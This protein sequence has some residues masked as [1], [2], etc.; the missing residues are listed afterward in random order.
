MTPDEWP[1]RRLDDLAAQVRMVASLSTLVATHDAKIDG[2][3]EE[4]DAI[5]EMLR[6][7]VVRVEKAMDAISVE[8]D[9]NSSRVEKK[10]DRQAEKIEQL[11]VAQR[12]TPTQW[13][14]VLGPALTALIGAVALVLTKGS[15]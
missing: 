6:E 1:D 3:G 9:R 15:P 14:A 7:A 10:V 8:C 2:Q 4:I 11:T 13:A 12:W 5:R